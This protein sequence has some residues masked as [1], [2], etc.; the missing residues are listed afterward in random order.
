MQPRHIECAWSSCTHT[1]KPGLQKGV[2]NL[3]ELEKEA[4]RRGVVEKTV[5]EVV[6]SLVDDRFVECEKIGSGNFYWSF[7]SKAF[8]QVRTLPW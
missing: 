1:S 3:K 6:K 7:P 4:G 8:V 5:E 2:Y